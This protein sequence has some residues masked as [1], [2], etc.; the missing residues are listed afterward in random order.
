MF[1]LHE[2]HVDWHI[3]SDNLGVARVSEIACLYEKCVQI[4]D[5]ILTL[6]DNVRNENGS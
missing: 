6:L 3:L 2:I 5:T 1:V 4:V